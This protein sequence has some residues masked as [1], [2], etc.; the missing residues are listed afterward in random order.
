MND[1]LE[2]VVGRILLLGAPLTT[3][4][5]LTGPVTDPVNVTKLFISG[6]MA[7][8]LLGLGLVFG[9][10]YLWS[11]QRVTILILAFF[12]LSA[13][14][15]VIQSDSPLGQNLYGTYA[16]N[17]GFFA[18][19]FMSCIFLG[20]LLIRS[21]KSFHLIFIG[22]LVAG[23]V[24]L[25]YCL[26]VI[27]FGDFIGW[28]NPYGNI[29]GLFGNPDFISAF[30]G[31]FAASIGALAFKSGV[32]MPLRVAIFAVVAISFY[33]IRDS[34]AIQGQAVLAT[35]F[36]IIFFYLVRAKAKNQI[37]TYFYTI[38]VFV[39]GTLAIFGTLQKGP[40]SFV[41]KRSVS[42]RGSYW[43]TAIDMG[44]ERPFSGVGMDAYGDWYRRARPPIALIDTPGIRTSSNAA[45]NVVLDFFA[46]GG[47]PLLISYLALLTMTII[48]IFRV[49][50]RN[51]NYDW[52][53]VA[54]TTA[55][56]C[57]EV[58]SVISINQ[59]GL[60]LW[61]WLLG[62]AL[63]SYEF[64]T[65]S[66][67]E[68]SLQQKNWKGKGAVKPQI[69]SPQLVAGIGVLVGLFLASPPLS[70][71]SKFKSALDSQQVVRVEAVLKPGLMNLSDSTRYGTAVQT[72]AN[73]NLPE[74]ALKYA[75][76]AVIFNPDFSSA[77]EQLYSLPNATL[78]EKK[79]AIKNLQRL[80]PLNPDVTVTQ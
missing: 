47:W 65:R 75:R 11:N 60:A 19:F 7:I 13:L 41:Y 18:Y 79:T 73:S 26:W 71:D 34:H 62:G 6:G 35:G 67:P 31:M 38:T 43:K 51:K 52:L 76:A 28:S 23:T 59:I 78:E 80:D 58:Q 9:L 24:N 1:A 70:S 56:V 33:T 4:F 53:F 44:T 55:W 50:K 20:T 29:L 40:F 77:W 54:L 68:E 69:F 27:S 14:N 3:L 21:M 8:A 63:I 12:N 49:T 30:L 22:L 36:A 25:V 74:L 42:L 15:A 45:H 17:T 32:S 2:R 37:L 46:S 10:G 48:S 64:L 39:I 16:R 57:Y 5:L 61:G 72:F 66:K